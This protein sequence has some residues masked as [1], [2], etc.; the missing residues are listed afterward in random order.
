MRPAGAA[1]GRGRLAPLPSA[2]PSAPDK[3]APTLRQRLARTMG[4]DAGLPEAVRRAQR[5]TWFAIALAVVGFVVTLIVGRVDLAGLL[6]LVLLGVFML[7]MHAIPR[8][9]RRG[10]NHALRRAAAHDHLVCPQC[11]YDLRSLDEAGTCPECG[12]ACE[13]EAVRA[14]WVDA[15]RRLKR[16]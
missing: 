12:R 3:P 9:G 10:V 7:A 8:F 16:T 15:Q 11:T 2:V 6:A 1:R 4:I 13:R 5:W 14:Q